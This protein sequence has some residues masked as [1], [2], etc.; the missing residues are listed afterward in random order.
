MCAVCLN[1]YNGYSHTDFH[2]ESVNSGAV[3]VM[4]RIMNGI[5]KLIQFVVVYSF[6]FTVL[7]FPAMQIDLSCSVL[8]F[9]TN[10]CF[11]PRDARSASG[12]LLS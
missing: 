4:P 10:V 1:Y 5:K 12:V 9:Q 6:C 7:H 8:H 2:N 3:D 11:L